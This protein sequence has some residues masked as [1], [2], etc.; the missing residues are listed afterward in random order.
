[1]RNLHIEQ[2]RGIIRNYEELSKELSVDISAMNRE[3][4]EKALILPLYEKY[5]SD[6]GN[7]INGQF[8]IVIKD[9]DR[10]EY[11]ALRDQF[12]LEQLFYYI[13][14]DNRILF[15]LSIKDMFSK[16][17]FKKEFDESVLQL[18]L[19]FTYIPGERTMFKGVRK[20]MPRNYLIYNE[21]GLEISTYF[22]PDFTFD[23][24]KSLEEWADD[25]ENAIKSALTQV[26]DEDEKADSFLSGG[27][28]SSY[29][30]AMSD[31]ETAYSASYDNSQSD[32]SVLAK[33]TAD[34]LGRK[35]VKYTVSPKL[36]FSSVKQ[37]MYDMES[38][39]G[40]ASALVFALSCKEVVKHSRLCYSGEGSDEW[41]GGYNI[42]RKA[43]D[44]MNKE[45]P[46]FCGNT[47]IMH[48]P[49]QK[50]IL[51]RYHD[52]YTMDSFRKRVYKDIKKNPPLTMMMD[53]DQRIFLE[54]SIFHNVRRI[55]ESSGLDIRT[56]YVDM[57]IYDVAMHAPEKYKICKEDNK[58]VLRT[59][60]QRVLPHEVA[61]R[62]KKGFPVPILEWMLNGEYNGVIYEALHSKTADM[63]FNIEEL[64]KLWD[65]FTDDKP[66]WWR[67]IW[68]IFTFIN[69]Y[70]AFFEN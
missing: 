39:T 33:A 9:D 56:P 38:P 11:F 61:W 47:Y 13:T 1:M 31:A 8:A 35:F 15:S 30:L 59:A 18:Y 68:T 43:D 65:E 60:A 67:K 27:I 69:W 36:Y 14:E 7:H 10:N 63:F 42:Y 64:D 3:Q 26:K 29:L 34:K 32:E 17:G 46:T 54:G 28:D 21:K 41:F 49:E 62:T 5:S 50:R 53:I 51:K 22:E 6:M 66:Q 48:T 37:F 16:D 20:L 55:S 2:Y 19:G 24:G 12:G 25:I 23:E 44:Y 4:R 40:D 70:E 57:R 58:I 45:N 52:D